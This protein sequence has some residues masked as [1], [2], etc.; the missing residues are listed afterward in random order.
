MQKISLLRLRNSRTFRVLIAWAGMSFL[1]QAL[2]PSVALALTSGPSQPE[3]QSFEP[4]GTSEMVDLFSGDFNYNI[5]LFELPGPNG[6]YPFNMAYHSGVGMDQ[7]ASWVG[8]GWN[9]NVGAINRSM[10]GLPDDF[11]GDE[12]KSTW[13]SKPNITFGLGATHN[14]EFFGADPKASLQPSLSAGVSFYYNNYRGVGYSLSANPGLTNQTPNREY[15][16]GGSLS[17]NSQEGVGVNTRF[18]MSSDLSKDWANNYSLGLGFQSKRGLNLSLS[19]ENGEVTKNAFGRKSIDKST[20]VS[21]S[22][23]YSFAESAYTPTQNT[24]TR[25]ISLSVSY[26]HGLGNVGFFNFPQFSGFFNEERLKDNGKEVATK[27]RGYQYLQNAEDADLTDFNRSKDGTVR[28]TSPNLAIPQLTYDYYNI[29]GQGTGGMFRPYRSDIGH[30]HDPETRSIS[31]GGSVGVETGPT[32]HLGF[33][34]SFSMTVSKSGPWKYSS[35]QLNPWHD[36]YTFRGSS[37]NPGAA[38]YEPVYYKVRGEHTSFGTDELDFIGE[39]GPVRAHLDKL[40]TPDLTKSYHPVNGTLKGNGTT[41]TSNVD[42]KRPVNDRMPRNSSVQPI[43]NELLL[44]QNGDELLGEYDIDIYHSDY[45]TNPAAAAHALD[46]ANRSGHAISA[47]HH[48]GFTVLNGGGMRHVYGLPAYNLVHEDRRFSI[49]YDQNQ[50][51]GPITGYDMDVDEVKYDHTGTDQFFNR[52]ELPPYAHAYLLTSVLGPD[53]VDADNIPGPSEGDFGYWVKFNYVKANEDYKWRAPF[54]GANFD[55]GLK[56]DYQDDKASF[57]YGEKEVYYLA[58]AET[59]TH[60]AEFELSAREDGYAAQGRF[61]PKISGMPYDVNQPSYKLD[62]VKLYVKDEAYTSNPQTAVPLQTTHFDYDYSL[63]PNTKNSTGG[64]NNGKLTLKKMWTTYQGNTR[65]ALSPYQFTY[66]DFNPGYTE[67]HYDRWGNYKAIP[68]GE[69]M[70]YNQEF[71][72]TEQW[73]YRL[74]QNYTN[75]QSQQQ[76]ADKHAG[77]WHLKSIQLPTGGVININY[78]ADDYAYVQ[79]KRAL[80]MFKINGIGSGNCNSYDDLEEAY[81]GGTIPF[82]DVER[83]VNEDKLRVYF[84]LEQAIPM[85]WSQA[86][87]KSAIY[88]QYIKPLWVPEEE[89]YQLYYKIRS[90]LKKGLWDDVSGYAELNVDNDTK[91]GVSCAKTFDIDGD[92]V[93][94]NAYMK[95]WVTLRLTKINGD[96]PYHPFAVAAWQHMRTN[97]PD[98]LVNIGNP[99]Q[100]ANPTKLQKA[101]KAKSLLAFIPDLIK[102][103]TGYRKW[104]FINNWGKNIDTRLS[105]IRLGNPD[106]KKLGGGSRVSSIVFSDEWS[107]LSGAGSGENSSEFGQFYDYSMVEEGK[108]ISSGVATYEPMIGGEENPFRYAKF[109]PQRIPMMTNNNLYFEYPVN[110]AYYPGASVGYRQVTVKSKATKEAM[111]NPPTNDLTTSTGVAEHRFYTAKD[112]PVITGETD[113]QKEPF[114]LFVPLPFIGQIKT[115]HLTASQGY[116]I[117]L[118]DMHGKPKS[119]KNFALDSEGKRGGVPVSSVEYHYS[120]TVVEKNGDVYSRLDNLQPVILDNG[121]SKSVS[122]GAYG[123]TTEDRLIGVEYEFF[124]DIRQ[125]R[126]SASTYGIAFNLDKVGTFPI[127]APWPSYVDINSALR[128]IATNKIIHKTGILKK[129]IAT[130]GQST[131]VTENKLF[132]SQTGRPLLTVVNNNYDD[133]VYNYDY[134]GYWEYSGMGPAADNYWFYFRARIN[135]EGNPTHYMISDPGADILN[136]AGNSMTAST[137][138]S[139]LEEGDEFIVTMNGQKTKAYLVAK[140]M[141]DGEEYLEFDSPLFLHGAHSG[142]YVDFRLTRSGKRNLLQTSIGGVVALDDPT[143]KHRENL[144]SSQTYTQ[145]DI[146]REMVGFL[147]SILTC[148]GDL[149]VREYNL[150]TEDYI[151]ATGQKTDAVLELFFD[152]VA[153]DDCNTGDCWVPGSPEVG[154]EFRFK[155]KGTSTWTD[156][157]HCVARQ[158]VDAGLTQKTVIDRFEFAS[159]GDIKVYYQNFATTAGPA[160]DCFVNETYNQHVAYINN[161]LQANAVEFRHSWNTTLDPDNCANGIDPL[162]I[163]PQTG[164]YYNPYRIGHKG[165]WRVWKQHH[166]QDERYQSEDA[167]VDSDV[168]LRQD[169]V[170]QG[171]WNGSAW[172]KRFYEFVWSPNLERGRPDAW[173]PNQTVTRYNQDSYQVENVDISG[174]Y[175]SALYGYKDNLSTAVGANM[176]YFEM[177]FESLDDPDS[178]FATHAAGVSGDRVVNNKAHTGEKS[179]EITGASEYA[180]R[181]IPVPGK[182]YWVSAWVSLPQGEEP[183]TASYL[184]S[185]ANPSDRT[186]IEVK[187]YDVNGNAISSPVTFLEPVGN[188]VEG[189]QKVEGEFYAPANADLGEVRLMFRS[190]NTGNQADRMLWDDIRFHPYDGNQQTYVYDPGNFRLKATLDQNN[191]ATFYE[192][193]DQGNLFLVRKETDRGIMTLQESRAHLYQIP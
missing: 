179:L 119:V 9:L 77:A 41:Y 89:N 32:D 104:A 23:T 174:I 151:D 19:R 176:G 39:E 149:E 125:S 175:S 169:G 75:T 96:V 12:V 157:C 31:M 193:D 42:N 28:R 10:R 156:D 67:H 111:D 20:S 180:T 113:I 79:N 60:I 117:E 18:S 64:A 138:Y 68:S 142:N 83:G 43:T 48:A 147:N 160:P 161:V 70:C 129:V 132:D 120:S 17:L 140:R 1:G 145:D 36:Y 13:H 44:D 90:E 4:I 165:I 170:F 50:E 182:R 69:N 173:L 92:G 66:S 192:Y 35:G 45:L 184:L 7:E 6:G 137:L 72:Y 99:E 59:K 121:D 80:Q 71:P 27:A 139:H 73:N 171:D 133:P 8:L 108:T 5:P 101:L 154:Y 30:V 49:L 109:Y 11:D 86:E 172:D 128:T 63:C 134:P 34:G 29:Q 158:W 57:L 141:Q 115:N 2:A 163:N 190:K 159:G 143:Q 107:V 189:W 183:Q 15:G 187:W 25:G 110:E 40:Y 152:A 87:I 97:N 144:L 47:R 100:P 26:K 94:E 191:F 65:G 16:V 88:E 188:M 53:Y 105:W 3:V 178:E 130:D 46:R 122:T 98:L 148:D 85:S 102:M 146:N 126:S 81:P 118:N 177:L 168:N 106:G 14:F 164:S 123:A 58:S 37:A 95:G 74:G 124:T 167:N 186:G 131:V 185:G 52:T 153:I 155:L 61:T 162:Y 38:D 150:E 51:C 62:K 114:N 54:R 55:P 24:P 21:G 116:S 135:G 93:A 84:H 127:A 22:S 82:S 136:Q 112:F 78:E 33:D 166:Y 91:Y 56:S 103:F 76:A 181:I